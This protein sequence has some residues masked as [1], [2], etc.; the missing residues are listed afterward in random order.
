MKIASHQISEGAPCFII[1]EAGLNHNGLLR[2]AKLLV[3][4]AV[5][6]GAQAVKFQKRDLKSLYRAEELGD[7]AGSEQ[8]FQYI[9]PQLE[10]YELP[11]TDFHE[12]KAYCDEKGI[13]FLCSPWDVP[14][15][16]FIDS[17]G[18]PA[19][20]VASAD[21]TNFILLEHLCSKGR[22][23]IVSTGMSTESEV[24]RTVEF[25][26]GRKADF[27]LLHCNSTYPAAYDELNLRCMP[28]MREQ[29]GVPVG[30][31]GHERGGAATLAAVALGA[32][33][34]EKHLTLDRTMKGPDHPASL[35]P[36]EFINL[37]K[38]IRVVERSLGSSH[39]WVTRGEF[40]NREVLGKSLVAACDIRKGRKITRETVTAKSPGKGIS[41]QRLGEL[42]GTVARRDIPPDGYF[43][44]SDFGKPLQ[45]VGPVDFPLPWGMIVRF[46]DI[47]KLVA[48]GPQI[49][50]F[51]LTEAD[52]SRHT[53]KGRYK[54]RLAVHMAEYIGE[55]LVD[56]CSCDRELRARSI[57]RIEEVIG[58]ALSIAPDFDTGEPPK[59]VIHPGG[60]SFEPQPNRAAVL[61]D[62]LADS[63]GQIN[64]EGVELLLENMP[65]LPWYFGGQWY[66]NV[67]VD[68]KEIAGLCERLN[69]KLC[70]DVSH[71]QL[72]CNYLGCDL[73]DYVRRLKPFTRHMHMADA[74]GKSG[75][76]LQIGE[77]EID[78]E[79][80]LLHLDG[81]DG[82]FIPEIWQGHKFGAEG[83]ILA[84]K[85]LADIASRIS[86]RNKPTEK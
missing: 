11:E 46:S 56:L 29:Y 37:V 2:I 64:T 61:L 13:I 65:P 9:L 83:F 63:L 43:V 59:I 85:R 40:M 45:E 44:E 24:A 50:E 60:M 67:F 7:R 47:D 73:M 30:Y 68:A 22:P 48:F 54:Q 1:A 71:A 8:Q 51:H 20:K 80:L 4:V 39:R 15:A 27:A 28:T 36:E 10:K 31:S 26:K 69:F 23:L 86:I 14:S 35:E 81:V 58:L 75:E 70:L 77:G 33:I 17:L 38:D 84:L 74:A 66:H 25:L 53:L 19:F 49:V 79:Q 6:A 42:L 76:G 5:I 34:I 3:D 18:V 12:L 41:P 72:A 32:R 62:N 16:D 52:L 78:F 55:N 21:M 57:R 82:Y